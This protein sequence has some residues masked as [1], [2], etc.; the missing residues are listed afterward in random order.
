MKTILS[1]LLLS[2][3]SCSTYKED[4]ARLDARYAVNIANL[5]KEQTNLSIEKEPKTYEEKMLYMQQ[6]QLRLLERQQVTNAINRYKDAVHNP[7]QKVY[8]NRY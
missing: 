8:F 7:T 3:T 2:L 5:Q 6:E 4:L 1:I